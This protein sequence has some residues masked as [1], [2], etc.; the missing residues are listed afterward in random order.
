VGKGGGKK[1]AKEPGGNKGFPARGNRAEH[2]RKTDEND[3]KTRRGIEGQAC[4]KEGDGAGSPACAAEK[5][6]HIKNCTRQI[7]VKLGERVGEHGCGC[8]TPF[9]RGCP[10]LGEKSF[11][12]PAPQKLLSGWFMKLGKGSST[13]TQGNTH[14]HPSF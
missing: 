14:L 2:S 13:K 11:H 6:S 5:D 8:K 1:R 10:E 9:S 12:D 7:L 3:K 4:Q